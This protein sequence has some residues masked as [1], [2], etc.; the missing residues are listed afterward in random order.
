M[1]TYFS[2]PP[3]SIA[4]PRSL[5]VES[6]KTLPETSSPSQTLI[7]PQKNPPLKPYSDPI[8]SPLASGISPL[9]L[10]LT[11][12]EGFFFPFSLPATK[13]KTL[14]KSSLK[15]SNSNPNLTKHLSFP[16]FMSQLAY[17]SSLPPLTTYTVL[18]FQKIH[19]V[20]SPSISTFIPLDAL[21]TRVLFILKGLKIFSYV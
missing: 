18:S 21:V 16:S 3:K 6:S 14:E 1:T 17:F 15:R 10:T 13:E 7:D 4:L 8:P 11:S 2:P 12:P 5:H 9:P 19:P 20:S